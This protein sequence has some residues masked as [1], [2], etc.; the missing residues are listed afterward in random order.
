MKKLLE[1]CLKWRLLVFAF[2]AIVAAVG[3]RSAQQLPIDAVPDITNVQVQV[4]TNVPALG[5]VDVERTIT[6]P[7]ESSMSGLPG[8]EQIRSVSRFGLSAVT[9]VFEEDTDLLRA[10]QL[11]SERLVQARERLPEGASP[12]LGPLSSGLGEIFQFEVRTCALPICPTPTSATRPWSYAPCST[13]SW[14]TSCAPCLASSRST[15]S[16]AS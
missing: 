1:L 12:E 9:I 4:L 16:A 15:R 3:V 11:I 10:R 14:P 6:F 5:P 13:G 2:V 8:V 7:V